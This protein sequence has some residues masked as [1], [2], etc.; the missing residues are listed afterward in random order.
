[1]S[2]PESGRCG[3]YRRLRASSTL[4]VWQTLFCNSGF[5]RCVRY[6]M[7]MSNALVPVDL[8]PDGLTRLPSTLRDGSG[9]PAA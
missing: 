9:R 6:R 8:L 5:H 3:L 1:M 2:C 7:S 4:A